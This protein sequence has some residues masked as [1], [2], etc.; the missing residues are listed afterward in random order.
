MQ[1]FGQG[2][3][4][5][6][7][8]RG[9]DFAEEIFQIMF[10]SANQIYYLA[11]SLFI[12]GICG[13]IYEIFR[14]FGLFIAK[15]PIII[16]SDFA[17]CTVSLFIYYEATAYFA[18]PSIRAYMPLGAIVGF[19]FCRKVCGETVFGFT[20]KSAVLLRRKINGRIKKTAAV[21]RGN[22]NG[23]GAFH[24]VVDIFNLASRGARRKA[25]KSGKITAGNRITRSGERTD[26]GRNRTVASRLENRRAGK[27]VKRIKYG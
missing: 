15:K 4:D 3:L 20:E 23:G 24:R 25:R 8:R 17:F 27:T 1:A 14:F 22:G 9:S 2:E 21:I 7:Y 10:E 26:T 12:G 16:I 19:L 13:L 11:E 6:I 18:F 5:K